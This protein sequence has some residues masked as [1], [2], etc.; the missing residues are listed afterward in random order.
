MSEQ[1]RELIN[2]SQAHKLL[3]LAGINMSQPTANKW[4]MEKGL[5]EQPTGPGGG[6]V[7][8]KTKLNFAIRTYL[9]ET[10]S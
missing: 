7:V 8:D 6:Y 3:I 2:A 1:K 9:K 4:L 10:R 5:A